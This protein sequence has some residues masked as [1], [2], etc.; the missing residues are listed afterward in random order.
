MTATYRIAVAGAINTDILAHASKTLNL[1][2][3]NLGRV[4]TCA[5]G[6]GLNISRNLVLLGAS[7]SLISAVGG[8]FRPDGLPSETR[9]M[10]LTHV[11]RLDDMPDS[12]YVALHDAD[13]EML[14]AVNDMRI[15]DELNPSLL[16]PAL[17]AIDDVDL[18]V[19][20]TNLNEATLDLLTTAAV[21]I[22][23]DPVSIAKAAR[24]EPFL[25]R[26]TLLK[27]NR[28]EAG[29]L[30]GQPIAT[31]EEAAIAAARLV[32]RGISIV[33]L[34]LG[35]AGALLADDR[36]I[37]HVSAAPGR[38]ENAT[39][40][41]DAMSAMLGLA[42]C[43]GHDLKSTGELAMA[44]ALVTLEHAEAVSPSV[45]ACRSEN[46]LARICVNKLSGL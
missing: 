11:T 1:H 13:G 24:I 17:E 18:L 33:C 36:E 16:V 8:S 10:D 4:Q 32:S 15:Y 29:A 21:P 37:L 9:Q 45:A 31:L 14:A 41:G 6:V 46:I 40:A 43:E 23:C 5:G 28:L 7:V 20:D 12:R 22:L 30:L 35:Q 3:S 19:V 2:D 34:S 42:F 25:H 38:I 39:G 26:L 44:A 27:P